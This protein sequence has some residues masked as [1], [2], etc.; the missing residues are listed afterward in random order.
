[1]VEVKIGTSK[2][3]ALLRDR[4]YFELDF[5]QQDGY[6]ITIEEKE[7]AETVVFACRCD[8]DNSHE[9]NI[10]KEYIANVLSDLVIN[11]LEEDL[12]IKILRNNYQSFSKL[13]EE[14]ILEIATDRLNFLVSQDKEE[15]IS[16][17][18][19]KNRVLL[20]IMDYLAI[21]EQIIIEGFVRFRL[22]N[23]LAELELAIDGAVDDYLVEKDYKEV[24]HLLKT[25][26]DQQSPQ[27]EL[28]NVVKTEDDRFQLL[29][30]K[31]VV[32]ENTFLDD[33][34][35]QMV[36]EDL[37]YQDLLISALITIAPVEIILHFKEPLAVVKTLEN[38]FGDRI[39]FCLG[40]QYCEVTDLTELDSEN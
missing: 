33:Y 36:E 2:Y 5:L 6:D 19:R 16:K 11:H 30:H 39:S 13:A 9:L 32:L 21:K 31:G 23:Y 38:V 37:D 34:T 20:E 7:Q 3:T 12:L 18:Q 15:I 27:N 8:S 40:C 1:M 28:V 29:N 14:R 25:F 26:I 10:F 4:L 17:I 24:V 22:Q 35:L